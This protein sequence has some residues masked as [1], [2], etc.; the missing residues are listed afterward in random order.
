VAALLDTLRDGLASPE[1][2][3]GRLIVVLG[4]GGDRDVA[5]RR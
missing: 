5:K 4:C 2:D 3:G 1:H